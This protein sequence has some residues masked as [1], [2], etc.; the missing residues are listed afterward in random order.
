MRA[1]VAAA[2]SG[3]LNATP[4]LVVSNNADC[5]ALD[6]ARSEGLPWR[7]I[8]ATTEGGAEA[9]D[10]AI[11]AAMAEAGVQLIVLSGYL[12]RLGPA[13]LRRYRSRILNIHP[14]LLPRYG[15]QGMYGRRVHEAVLA[16]RDAFTGATVHLVDADYDTG[17]IIALQRVAVSPQ[18]TVE[19]I[20]RN[21]M[22]VEPDLF[23][24]TLR[25]LAEGSLTLPD[26]VS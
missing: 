1:I 15:G 13:T 2:R 10:Q 21:V 26:P 19:D 12:R 18:D 24:S 20:E 25:Q 4:R 11:A 14:A 3:D 8:S 9:A 17:P 6:Y 22:A 16:N 7:H 5:P 23:V